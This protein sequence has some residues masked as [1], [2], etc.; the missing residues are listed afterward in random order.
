M[1]KPS[2]LA[3]AALAASSGLHA[4][5][6]FALTTDNQILTLDS[7]APTQGSA[8]RITGLDTS[9]R[10]LGLDTRPT[11]GVLYTLSNAGKLYTLDAATGVAALRTALT[12]PLYWIATNA[13]IDGAVA[14]S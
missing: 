4:E 1:I 3:V 10:L 5:T 6:L 12:A 9:E 14:P 2:L 8:V 11:T 13:G 7:T